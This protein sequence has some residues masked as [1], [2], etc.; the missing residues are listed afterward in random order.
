MPI[1]P[2]HFGLIP[3][4]N[5]VT[6]RRMSEGAFILANIITDIPVVLN[7]YG[8]AIQDL[9]GPSTTGA[10]HDTLTHNFAGALLLGLALGLLGFK[11]SRW[12]LG[13]VL[14]TLTH[15]G[16][17]MF[18]HSDVHP[19]APWSS[20]NP[21][22]FDGAHGLLSVALSVG[23]AFWILEC[24]DRLKA[25]RLWAPVSPPALQRV[26]AWLRL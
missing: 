14:G 4:L 15:V 2:L 24:S 12:W 6:R 23:V 10:L 5:R 19:F 8:E 1:T 21:F 17:D 18:V 22:Y 26:R 11:S 13:C 20:L 7:V 9:G 3:L 25:A 16:L